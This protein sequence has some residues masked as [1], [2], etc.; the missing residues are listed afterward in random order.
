MNFDDFIK[1][2]NNLECSKTKYAIKEMKNDIKE[3]KKI[4]IENNT[5]LLIANMPTSFFTGHKVLRTNHKDFIKRNN[6]DSLYER[7]ALENNLRYVEL[8]NEFEKLENKEI[9]FYEF[10]GHPTKIGYKKIAEEIGD[11]LIINFLK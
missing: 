2:N 10:D 1:Y 4:C 6:I 3:M 7:I 5:E 8:T 9:Y 11:N